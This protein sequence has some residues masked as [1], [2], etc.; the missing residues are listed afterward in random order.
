MVQWLNTVASQQEG[1]VFDSHPGLGAIVLPLSRDMHVR[2]T[3][4]SKL[5]VGV[6]VGVLVSLSS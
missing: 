2:F 5:S 4:R 6:S 3:G 1:C